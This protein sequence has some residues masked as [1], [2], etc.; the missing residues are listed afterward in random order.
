M[1]PLGYSVDM[2]YSNRQESLRPRLRTVTERLVMTITD[3]TVGVP[4]SGHVLKSGNQL[5]SRPGPADKDATFA[6]GAEVKVTLTLGE[7]LAVYCKLSPN[8]RMDRT[9]VMF[10]DTEGYRRCT[11]I[12]VERLPDGCDVIVL[13]HEED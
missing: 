12:E 11:K 3:R 13:S 7:L 2:P 5:V 6:K 4:K 9:H 8:P 10:K 1:S